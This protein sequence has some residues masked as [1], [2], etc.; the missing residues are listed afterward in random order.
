MFFMDLYGSFW[1]LGVFSV[2]M[3]QGLGMGR[4]VLSLQSEVAWN[5]VLLTS[6]PAGYA[7]NIGG[8]YLQVL[9]QS[10][11]LKSKTLKQHPG[12]GVVN[13][14]KCISLQVGRNTCKGFPAPFHDTRVGLV[15]KV[16]FISIYNTMFSSIPIVQAQISSHV[17]WR[18]I[19][20]TFTF[21]SFS[22]R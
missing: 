14:R 16:Q 4:S 5:F 6:C 22:R 7:R 12:K 2:R 15:D 8:V 1:A 3:I 18:A 10:D 9:W 21:A 11:V 13:A 17:S 20:F 19:D